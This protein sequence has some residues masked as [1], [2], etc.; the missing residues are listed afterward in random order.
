M[1]LKLDRVPHCKGRS[2]AFRSLLLYMTCVM[3]GLEMRVVFEF[4]NYCYPIYFQAE[5]QEKQNILF[6]LFCV[7]GRYS[8]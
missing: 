5:Y 1:F 6:I 3:V 7:G 4:E 2:A 8:R